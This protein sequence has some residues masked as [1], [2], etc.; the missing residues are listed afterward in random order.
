MNLIKHS[1]FALAILTIVGCNSDDSNDD[2]TTAESDCTSTQVLDSS[3]GECDQTLAFTSEY[4][5]AVSGTTRTITS[6]SIPSHMVGLFGG[7][8]GS[9]NPN[10]ITEQSETYVI[11]TTPA[12]ASALTPLLST[13]GNGPNLGPQYSFGVLLNGVELDP[14][15]AEPFPHEGPLSANV[16]WEWNLEALNVNLGLD[17]NNAHVQP[18]GKYHYHGS[19][20]LFLENLNIPSN[21]MTLIGYAAD[22]F[23]MYYKY[24]YSIGTDNTS[25]IIEMTSSYQLKSGNR[26]GDGIT[27]PCDVYNG[28]YS[29]DY[30][31]ITDLG[32]LDQ[33]NGRTGVTPEYPAGTYYYVITDD[34]PSIPRYFRGTP[35]EDFKIGQ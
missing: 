4:N 10:A 17:C 8:T 32:T 9:L 6:N 5:E 22:G 34:F 27:A 35:S 28:V 25:S 26:G 24:A 30:E 21:Q 7:G 31:F 23:P 11:T 29:N 14:V 20:I 1:V 3:R 12:I 13:T 19:P 33:A 18:T 2:T 16:N 15:A